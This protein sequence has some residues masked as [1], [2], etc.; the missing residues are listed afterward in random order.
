MTQFILFIAFVLKS[1]LSGIN[2]TT[3]AFFLLLYEWYVFVNQFTSN[4]Y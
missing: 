2:I 4:I 1:S 3:P